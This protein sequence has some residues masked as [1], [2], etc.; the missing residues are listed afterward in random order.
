MDKKRTIDEVLSL[1]SGNKI[2]VD[3]LL[4]LNER[5][6]D[7]IFQLRQKLEIQFQKKEIEY[8]CIYCKQPVVLRGRKNLSNYTTHYYFSHPYKS[9]DC[10][11]KNQ[12]S[13]TEEQIR[14]IKYN[15]EKESELHNYLK[16]RI[17]HFL[18]Q[19]N[20]VNSV[21][22]EKVVKHDEISRKWR[23]PDILALF[24]DKIIAVELQLSTTF[25]SV[26]VGRTLFYNDKGFF[27]LWIFPNFS[28]DSYIQKFTQKDIFYN[29]NSNVYV[30]DKEAELKS[31][32]ENE[33]IIKCHYK[34]YKIE[35]E[36]IIDS[37]ET[38]LIR[39]SQITFDFDTKQY[40]FYNSENEK[41][42]FEK[43][44]NKR[45]REKVFTERKNK[46]ENKVKRAID[47]IRKF[48][49][50]DTTPINEFY[51][52]PVK[53]LVDSDE[54][55]LLNKKLGFQDDNE[56]FIT[57]LFS[58][59]NKT[60]FL[61]FILE[62]RKISVNKK[63][64]FKIIFE[65]ENEYMFDKYIFLLFKSGYSLNAQE[66]TL[67]ENNRLSDNIELRRRSSIIYIYSKLRFETDFEIS[68]KNIKILHSIHSLKLNKVVGFRYKNLKGINN[69]IFEQRPEYANLYIRY[70]KKFGLY[71]SFLKEDKNKTFTK[72]IEQLNI[73]KPTQNI[74]LDIISKLIFE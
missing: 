2:Y 51:Y 17:A 60:N 64:I 67:L 66:I 21:K 6:Q 49:K 26:I 34:K 40:W 5:E 56:S 24:N 73:L 13:L 32:V 4:N 18:N 27:L 11:I 29:N 10:I 62:E 41:N 25:L 74:G 59:Q 63:A 52:D 39:L 54:I 72:K 19:N 70:L 65:Y 22:V 14:C 3:S 9:N 23:K 20:E 31:E 45:S 53:S 57:K 68:R 12:N 69:Y 36:I 38:E 35:N 28:L 16:N 71:D 43:E 30:F 1:K 46:I 8:V 7:K 42:L 55:E 47:F 37:W 15:G 50:N 33:L 48:Y 61:K 58:N 44:I